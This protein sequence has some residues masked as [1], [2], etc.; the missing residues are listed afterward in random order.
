MALAIKGKTGCGI[1]GKPLKDPIVSFPA[2][3]RFDHELGE[4]SDAAFHQSCFESHPRAAE[5]S[6]IYARYRAIWDCRPT[7][8]K[9]LEEIE[10]WGRKA[11]KN[12]P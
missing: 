7:D 9:T 4:F 11:F 6:E 12:F 8:L 2:F 5:V 3:L 1:C 10:A